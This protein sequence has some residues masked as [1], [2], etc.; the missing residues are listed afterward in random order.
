[1]PP[2]AQQNFDEVVTTIE[3]SFEGFHVLGY[4]AVGT[5]EIRRNMSPPWD[6]SRCLL[7]AGF[8]LDFSQN[9]KG[10]MATCSC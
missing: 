7:R 2:V 3:N 9:L 6:S 4:D 10:L 8:L 5:I 1:M